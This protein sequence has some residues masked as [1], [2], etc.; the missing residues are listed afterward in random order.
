MFKTRTSTALADEKAKQALIRAVNKAQYH[1]RRL[2]HNS[3]LD[4]LQPQER[5]LL[6]ELQRNGVWTGN[7]R[8]CQIPDTDAMLAAARSLLPWVPGG[9][10]LPVGGNSSGSHNTIADPARLMTQTPELFCWGLQA[11]LLTFVECYLQQPVA[12]LGVT[13]HRS[14][15]NGRQVGTRIWHVDGEDYRMIKLLVYLNDVD[16][17]GGPFEYIPR[18]LSPSYQAFRGIAKTKIDDEAMANVVP[19][20]QWRACVGEADTA[21][22]V[23][24]TVVFHHGRLPDRDRFTLT[25]SYTSQQPRDLDRC[26]NAFPHPALITALRDQLDDR[27]WQAAMGWRAEGGLKNSAN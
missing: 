15:A 20:D 21:I 7:I 11:Q 23:D 22:W 12:Y 24:P 25:F 14:V 18:G 26:R 3:P 5:D 27:Q 4:Q 1:L 9:E 17:T 13:L 8:Q 10:Y 16:R 6:A 2:Q 19:R